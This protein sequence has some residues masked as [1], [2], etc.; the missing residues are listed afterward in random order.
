MIDLTLRQSLSSIPILKNIYSDVY[1]SVVKASD[2]ATII[3][4]D[5]YESHHVGHGNSFKHALW[6]ML[7]VKYFIDDLKMTLKLALE[8]SEIVGVVQER[9]AKNPPVHMHS[10]IHNNK[11]GLNLA[12]AH[13]VLIYKK[14]TKYK[15]SFSFLFGFRLLPYI[16]KIKCETLRHEDYIAIHLMKLSIDYV[17]HEDQILNVN[18]NTLVGVK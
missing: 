6:S 17:T 11:V 7:M 9:I 3:T 10:D 4:I 16:K 5:N 15:F 1:K 14:V 8:I 2:T 12:P 18:K 13:M